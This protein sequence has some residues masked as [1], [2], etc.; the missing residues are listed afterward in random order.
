MRFSDPNVMYWFWVIVIGILAGFLA[1]KLMRGRGFGVLVDLLV[2]IV[3]SF[4]GGWV[5]GML[6][7]GAYGLI[8]QLLVSLV[9]ALLLLFL[10][11]LIKSA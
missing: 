3:G 4:I 6:G 7:I 9:G 1:G 2:G 10:I 5:F 8:G 11:R